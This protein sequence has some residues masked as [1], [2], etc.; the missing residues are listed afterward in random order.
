MGVKLVSLRDFYHPKPNTAGWGSE[1]ALMEFSVW[2]SDVWTSQRHLRV[3]HLL[4]ILLLG[5]AVAC[6]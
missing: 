2:R 1:A 3:N 4:C 6:K 5:V